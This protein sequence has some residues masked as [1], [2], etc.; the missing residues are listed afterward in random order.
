[1][2]LNYLIEPTVL[3]LN[4]IKVLRYM[5]IPQ[6]VLCIRNTIVQINPAKSPFYTPA[7]V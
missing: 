5:I 7:G 4:R 6:M 1:M 3:P 2:F